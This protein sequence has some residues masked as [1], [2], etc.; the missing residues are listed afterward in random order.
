VDALFALSPA[1]SLVEV[2]CVTPLPQEGNPKPR[3]FR[4]PTA[5]ALINRYGFNS[6]GADAVARRLRDR[7]RRYA[8]EREMSE[9]EVLADANTRASLLPGRLLAVQ[10]GK[11]G[12]TDG[13]D[14]EAVKRDY[15]QCVRKLADWADVL[16][17]NVSSPN[18][19]GLRKLQAEQPLRELLSAVVAAASAS[20]VRRATPPKVV[21]KVSPDS[22]SPAEISAIC[23][24]VKVTGIAGVIVANTTV[25]RPPQLTAS[26]Q[27][28]AREREIAADEAGGLSGPALFGKTVA[29]VR[30][31]RERLGS[32][33]EVLAS[34][35][36]SSGADAMK[37][38]EAGAS[39]VMAYTGVVYGGVGWF[40]RAA[41]ELAQEA[42]RRRGV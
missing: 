42:R 19:P 20:S 30:E 27:T 40:G 5:R 29:L 41:E 25:S 21:V 10:I 3:V 6:D 37:V 35:G 13:S 31:F 16:V 36:V 33:V 1:I 17:V 39:A 23:D 26:P 28:T 4:L 24:A 15:V 18:T 22:D 12:A 11:N 2:G 14:I 34:G 9:E 38:V 8:R 7:V 32:D